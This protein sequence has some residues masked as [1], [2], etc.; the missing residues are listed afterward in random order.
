MVRYFPRVP[1][2][3]FRLMC[4]DLGF[5]FSYRTLSMSFRICDIMSVI[6]LIFFLYIVQVQLGNFKSQLLLCVQNLLWF[7]Y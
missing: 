4:F 7:R 3:W 5:L 6:N 1:V 2:V